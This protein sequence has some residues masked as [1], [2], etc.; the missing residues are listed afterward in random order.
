MALTYSLAGDTRTADWERAR[1]IPT[2]PTHGQT[3]IS[4]RHHEREVD[5]EFRKV[6]HSV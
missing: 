2:T 5:E 6:D 4:L 3:D 1:H